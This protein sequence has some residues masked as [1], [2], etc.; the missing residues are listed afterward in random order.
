MICASVPE[1]TIHHDRHMRWAEH[2]IGT[3]R[4]RLQRATIHSKAKTTSVQFTTNPQFWARV[5]APYAAHTCANDWIDVRRS[6]DRFAFP[7][8]SLDRTQ[9]RTHGMCLPYVLMKPIMLLAMIPAGMVRI[10]TCSP[11]TRRPPRILSRVARVFADTAE[12]DKLLDAQ[13]TRAVRNYSTQSTRPDRP[14][15][16]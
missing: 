10:G 2:H 11:A 8:H 16:P 6:L 12:V 4:E 15:A 1:A 7:C 14:G 3:P 5:P 13:S 9:C